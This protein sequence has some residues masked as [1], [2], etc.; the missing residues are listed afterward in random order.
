MQIR[1]CALK[2]SSYI[3]HWAE[4]DSDYRYY[5]GGVYY[6]VINGV[7]LDVKNVNGSTISMLDFRN[8]IYR[9]G[10]SRWVT[11]V[12]LQEP[13]N[14]SNV[15]SVL[16]TELIDIQH[17]CLN[18][19]A[20]FKNSD[21]NVIYDN[22]DPEQ[23]TFKLLYS[24]RGT[25]NIVHTE[26]YTHIGASAFSKWES[27]SET[28][29]TIYLSSENTTVDDEMLHDAAIDNIYVDGNLL[30]LEDVQIWF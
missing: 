24:Y 1:E 26:T 27:D 28:G 6:L 20:W 25:S 3:E 7:L 13:D 29:L 14:F 18:E 19:T 22:P 9:D 12:D 30:T 5:Y 17:N 15:T 11:K 8:I 2:D 23:A 21:V 10:S 16:G 4:Y